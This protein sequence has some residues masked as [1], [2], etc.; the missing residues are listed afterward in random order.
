[1]E[2]LGLVSGRPRPPSTGEAGACTRV[3]ALI[4]FMPTC[5]PDHRDPLPPSLSHLGLSPSQAGPWGCPLL[6]ELLFCEINQS[7]TPRPP[8]TSSDLLDL[9]GPGI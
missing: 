3:S 1:M 2:D 4:T 8:G 5:P 7:G 6:P 9:T